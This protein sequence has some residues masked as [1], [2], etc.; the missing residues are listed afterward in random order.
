MRPKTVDVADMLRRAY[1]TADE[2]EENVYLVL[3]PRS[4]GGYHSDLPY[5]VQESMA[6]AYERANGR[7][8]QWRIK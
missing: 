2:L 6:D 3:E 5:I 8:I 7:F 1:R 4:G